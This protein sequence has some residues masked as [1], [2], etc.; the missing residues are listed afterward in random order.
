MSHLNA[1]TICG[2]RLFSPEEN[3]NVL[4]STP[5]TLFLGQ[6]GCGKTTIIECI[7]YALTGEIPA[8]TNNGHGFLNDPGVSDVSITKGNVELKYTDN[9]GNVITV[10][11]F[12]QVSKQPDGKMQF[13]SLDVNIRKEELNGQTNYISARCEDADDFCCNSL[14]VSR[15]ILNHVLF[16]HQEN[17][18]WPLDQPEK[19]EEQFD[20][21]FETVKY[22]KYIDFVRQDI[23]NKQ[24]ELKVL[25]QKVETKRIINEEVEK[26]RAKFEAK[27]TEF[28]E[29][30]N[31]IQE[32]SDE[33][34][35]LEDR[36]KQICDLGESIG[37]LQ[38]SLI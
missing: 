5:V 38:P 14:G 22:N 35:P 29:I 33:I 21:I 34:Q 16:C 19:V 26:C 10:S 2:V 30:Q 6:N 28:D 8:G 7:R 36:M 9:T 24:L 17:S 25:E 4:F 37:S 3:Q 18:Y 1:L 23:K 11:R 13:K 12:M 31:K 32:K 20:E 15:S 27:Q